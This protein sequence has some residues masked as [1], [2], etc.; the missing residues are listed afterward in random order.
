M[1]TGAFIAAAAAALGGR[2]RDEDWH[3]SGPAGAPMTS[4][5]LRGD[6]RPPRSFAPVRLTKC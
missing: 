5:R 2:H 3:S 1:L 6:E 4:G